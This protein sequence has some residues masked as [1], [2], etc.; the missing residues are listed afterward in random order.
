MELLARADG[1][2]VGAAVVARAA[3]S[4]AGELALAVRAGLPAALLA[5]H[6]HPHPAW[7]EALHPAARELAKQGRCRRRR[8]LGSEDVCTIELYD[9][10]VRLPGGPRLALRRADGAGR[11]FLLV[12]GLAS[13]ARLWDGVAAG[14]RLPGTTSSPSTC[15]ATAGPTSPTAATTSTPSPPTSPP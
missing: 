15:A 13:N 5:D 7:S 2:L 9:D 4:W 12:H 8:Q 6:V 1:T 3:D 11:P 14:S 10:E